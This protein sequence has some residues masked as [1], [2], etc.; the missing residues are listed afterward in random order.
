MKRKE[1]DAGYSQLYHSLIN[2]ILHGAGHSSQQERQAAF[3][4]ADLPQ[5]LHTLLN[6][7]AYEAYKVTDSDIEAVKQTGVNEDQLFELIVCAA[8]GQASRQ[9]E[10]GLAALAAAVKQ[11]GEHAS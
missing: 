2:R 7:V 5:P 1:T 10:N 6:K 9:Y 3:S 8:V 11:G 4:N